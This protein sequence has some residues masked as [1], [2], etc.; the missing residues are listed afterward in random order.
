MSL[1][2]LSYCRYRAETS[3]DWTSEHWRVWNIV[4]AIKGKAMK[5]Y[6]S[7]EI[8]GVVRRL[9]SNNPQIAV[10]W[11]VDRVQLE[12][13]FGNGIYLLCPIP[14]SQCTPT[15]AHVS[16]TMSLAQALFKRISQ[17]KVWPHLKFKKPMPRKIRDGKVLYENLV[18]TAEVPRGY[19][20]LLDDVCTTGAHALASQRRLLEHGARDTDAGSQVERCANRGAKAVQDQ[21]LADEV[22]QKWT[23]QESWQ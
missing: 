20:I 10:D 1:N 13:R 18:C 19:L 12:T 15:S 17:L 16:A 14:S 8:G 6:T 2:N 11:F 9:D 22:A 3:S 21:Q 7:V 23:D 5:G 4:Q